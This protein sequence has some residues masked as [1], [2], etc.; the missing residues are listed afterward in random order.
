LAVV[1]ADQPP[2][3]QVLIL[4][5]EWLGWRVHQMEHQLDT[6]AVQ[7]VYRECCPILLMLQLQTKWQLSAGKRRGVQ[8]QVILTGGTSTA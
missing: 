3:V 5:F 7:V 8:N 4:I 1:S 2:L 6:N